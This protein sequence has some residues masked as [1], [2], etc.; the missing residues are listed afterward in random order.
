M[1][2]SSFSIG[3]NDEVLSGEGKMLLLRARIVVVDDVDRV[4]LSAA[5]RKALFQ[6]FTHSLT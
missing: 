3:P 4:V 1:V 5:Q 6:I 2:L